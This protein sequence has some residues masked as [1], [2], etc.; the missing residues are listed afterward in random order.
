[1]GVPILLP[2][3]RLALFSCTLVLLACTCGTAGA[4]RSA[5]TSWAAPEIATVVA[6][7]LM[8]S[9]L[10]TFRPDDPLTAGDL[11]DVLAAFGLTS[12]VA[13]PA[14]P[15]TM[16]ELDA[17]LVTASGLR[18]EAREIREAALEAG[19]SP[20][21]YLG[22]ETVARLLGLRLNHP[23]AQEQLELQLSQPATRA[24]AAYSVARLLTISEAE[25]ESVRAEAGS[26][27]S[28]VLTTWQQAVLR[29]ALHFVGAPYVWAGM[30]ERTQRLY[31]G[32]MPGGFDCSGFVWRVYKLQP[33][34]GAPGLA[35]VLKGR[36]TYTMS[37]EVPRSERIPFA[38]LEPADVVF[39]GSRGPGSTP[40]QVT[41]MGIYLGNG[42]IVHSSDHGVTLQP[43]TGWY[44]T[45]F[46]WARRPLAE[47]GL[48]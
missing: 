33:F 29:R 36:T 46:A 34:A 13:D 23:R 8:G 47:A 19:L 2:M 26:F 24:E 12:S 18:P 16:R 7:G 32:T 41:H 9:D 30:S 43:L 44:G 45:R 40:A 3:R 17:R 38:A 39:F 25:L 11:A 28:P 37:G 6:D 21:Q 15:V 42:W 10:D 5:S 14:R 31:D 4:Q 20:T 48:E 35:A 27:V 1:V 22:T